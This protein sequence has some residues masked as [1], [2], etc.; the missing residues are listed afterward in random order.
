MK[1]LQKQIDQEFPIYSN[2]E[3]IALGNP[4][5]GVFFYRKTDGYWYEK[6]SGGTETVINI[7]PK[8]FTQQAIVI[9]NNAVANTLTNA[10]TRNVL[11]DFAGNYLFT[12]SFNYNN[13]STNSDMQVT[14]TWNGAALDLNNRNG[15]PQGQFQIL[16]AEVKD[17]AN[18]PAGAITGTGSGQKYSYTAQFLL[19]NQLAGNSAFSI[20]I[21]SE[22][23]L[24][25]SAIW[26]IVGK[27]EPVQVI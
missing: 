16:R 7:L 9:H 12:L 15:D 18:S 2:A 8:V 19:Q 13:N 4:A 22:T 23:A 3:A 11:L 25:N 26:N 6:D 10:L 14:A 20:N 1:V 17:A 5:S 24:V 21:G 27:I